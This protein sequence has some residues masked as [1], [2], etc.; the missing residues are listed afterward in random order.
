MYTHLIHL[1]RKDIREWMLNVRI[2]NE[3][4]PG[5]RYYNST[6]PKIDCFIPDEETNPAKAETWYSNDEYEANFLARKMAYDN[7]GCNVNIY[8]LVNVHKSSASLPAKA[9]MT[10]KGLVP[11]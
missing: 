1:E 2:D 10:E 11:E 4:T 5:L 7:P 9:I 6:H 3:R 8:K